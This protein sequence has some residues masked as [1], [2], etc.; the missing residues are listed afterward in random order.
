MIIRQFFF[1]ISFFFLFKVPN[2]L[3]KKKRQ[4]KKRKG[5][6]K[7]SKQLNRKGKT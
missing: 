4:R 7:L 2:K 1:K 3:E 5:R 6:A